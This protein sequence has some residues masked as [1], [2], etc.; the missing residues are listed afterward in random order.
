[1]NFLYEKGRPIQEACW[2]GIPFADPDWKLLL[3]MPLST[4]FFF[5]IPMSLI[6]VLYL[7]IALAL[8]RS[9]SLRRCASSEAGHGCEAERSQ[10]QCRK[11]VVRMLG[12]C[13]S[14]V[15]QCVEY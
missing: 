15:F 10:V 7:N 4:L 11:M 2:C 14:L 6:L 5:V 12:E 13:F 8:R 9:G 3:L 1:M